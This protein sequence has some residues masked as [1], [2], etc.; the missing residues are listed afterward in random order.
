MTDPRP[1]ALDAA[2]ARAGGDQ[3]AGAVFDALFNSEMLLMLTE[4]PQGDSISPVLL[5]LEAGPTAL[6]FD[7]VER[8][9]AFVDR[10]APYAAMPGRALVSLLAARAESGAPVNLAVNP[11]V[12]PS[13][14][15][16]DAEAL[17]WAAGI[18]A[19]A[20]ARAQA[21]RLTAVEPPRAAPRALLEALDAKLA[22]L[23]PVLAE[24]W[25]VGVREEGAPD[26]ARLAVV[27][28]LRAPG[29][30]GPAAQAIAET[31]LLADPGAPPLDVAFAEEG[32]ALLSRARAAGLGFAIAPPP[33]P[34]RPAAPG[35]DPDRPPRLR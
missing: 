15:F 4:E 2:F 28:R 21:Q 35:A 31:G 13:E 17:R 33:E 27:A 22:A 19:Q 12:A 6:A 10:P 5:A 9:A 11:G 26:A 25:L 8:L 23:S 1:T 32:D 30:E 18:L 14:L 24:A 7:R 34:R 16:Y 20:P 3:S 29:A